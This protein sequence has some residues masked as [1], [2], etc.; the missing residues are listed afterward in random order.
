MIDQSLVDAHIEK[1]QRQLQD[2]AKS[3]FSWVQAWNTYAGTFFTT[4]FGKPANC[5]GQKHVDEVLASLERVQ[6]SIFTNDGGIAEYLKIAIQER[7]SVSAIP[8]GYLYFPTDLGGLELH[9][10]FIPLLQIRDVVYENPLEAVTHEVRRSRAGSLS[11][12]QNSIRGWAY[13]SQGPR[14]PNLRTRRQ[15]LF[16]VL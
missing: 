10:T 11:Q 15:R 16:H 8:D 5:Y 14:R 12:S 13:P 3:I 2:K 4:N 9:N 7:F 1:L 6:R